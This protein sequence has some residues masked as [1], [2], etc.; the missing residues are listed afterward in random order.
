VQDAAVEELSLPRDEHLLRP[1]TVIDYG[2][3]PVV[4]RKLN[5]VGVIYAEGS[6]YDINGGLGRGPAA[7]GADHARWP[8]AG[9]ARRHVTLSRTG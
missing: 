4:G 5:S 6:P 7:L 1:G 9:T 2:A 8:I 3:F